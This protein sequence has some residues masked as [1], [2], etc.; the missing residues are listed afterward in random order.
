MV[1]TLT[2]LNV[3]FHHICVFTPGWSEASDAPT[4]RAWPVVE[5]GGAS[6]NPEKCCVPPAQGTHRWGEPLS[7]VPGG[8][9][10]WIQAGAAG[11]VGVTHGIP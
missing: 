3:P 1:P 11:N 6:F 4:R 10:G 7:P 2:K 8:C 5:G 9:S